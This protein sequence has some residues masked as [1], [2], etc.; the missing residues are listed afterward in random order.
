MVASVS[1]IK[2]FSQSLWMMW[3]NLFAVVTKFRS[4]SVWKYGICKLVVLKYHGESI[5]CQDG[6]RI[7]PGDWVGEL[8][9]D[10]RQVV[11]L[12]RT[13][14]ADRAGIRTARML[15]EA[16]KEISRE[17]DCNP[18]L[19][20]VQALTGITLLH[21]GIIHGIGFEQHPIK[22]KWQRRWFGIYLRFLLRMLHPEG[23]QR[24][25]DSTEKLSP[26]MLVLSKQSL[27]ARFA[28]RRK[29]A[30]S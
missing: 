28:P 18:E 7:L 13:L 2:L 15:R 9:L 5:V 14:G 21:R 12:T 10:N 30:V 26:K 16:M 24:L 19:S 29:E 6:H 11:Q 20:K 22:S 3:E 1:F 17:L 23:R 25:E 27:K 4:Q 8:H